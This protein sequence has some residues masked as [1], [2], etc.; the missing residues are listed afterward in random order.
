LSGGAE[1]VKA[2]VLPLR[3]LSLF[4]GPGVIKA[5]SSPLALLFGEKKEVTVES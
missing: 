4:F 2:A 5:V 3:A 1:V